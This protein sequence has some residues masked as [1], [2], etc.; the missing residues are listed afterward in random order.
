M[1]Y[2]IKGI[3]ASTMAVFIAGTPIFSA[4]LTWLLIPGTTYTGLQMLGLGIIVAGLLAVVFIDEK[5]PD[6]LPA[7]VK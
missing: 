1:F 2:V 5:E 6:K 3:P 7:A 4:T